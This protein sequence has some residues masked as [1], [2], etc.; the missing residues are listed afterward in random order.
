MT[1][2]DFIGIMRL[3]APKQEVLPK[4]LESWQKFTEEV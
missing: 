3:R 2:N 1:V 4:T